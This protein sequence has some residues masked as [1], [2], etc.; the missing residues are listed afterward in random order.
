MEIQV[1]P[2]SI[3]RI[4]MMAGIAV[5]LP[6]LLASCQKSGTDGGADSKVDYYTCT[7]HPS[8]RL[9][10]PKAKCP[11]CGMDL[12]PVYKK[13]PGAHSAT[14]LSDLTER[15]SLADQVGHV[16]GAPAGASG[17]AGQDGGMFQVAPERLQ[18][19]GV[20]TEVVE[21]RSIERTLRAPGIAV[22]NESSLRDI[23][24]KVAGGFVEK[25][26]ANYEGKYVEKGQPLMTV[27]CEGWIE[28]QMDYIKAYR[29]WRRT[30]DLSP[31][32]NF[33]I[34]ENEVKRRRQRLRV[35]DLSEEQIDELEK[36]ARDTSEIDTRLARG[37][38]GTFDILSPVSGHVHKKNAIEGM[39]FEAG[40]SLLQLVDLSEI[41]IDAQFPE[42]Q[43]QYLQVGEETAITFPSQPN[44]SF[45]GKVMFI[46]PHFMEDTRRLEVRISMPN[47]HHKIRPG[48]Y[49]NVA[50]Q[51]GRGD[52]LAVSTSAV[53]PTGEHYVVFVDHGGGRLEARF[54]K[55]GETFGNYYEVVSGLTKGERVVSS[56]NFLIDAESRIQG[57]LK[58][59]GH[60]SE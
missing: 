35:W 44:Q 14:N 5:I 23:N 16:H 7:M 54:I 4:L 27:L 24:L 15:P 3:S 58:T 32:N 42:D 20:T 12:V 47:P 25:L 37:L 17:S 10:D 33:Y 28:A 6:G 13:A 11:I 40:Q 46:N 9:K 53:I 34:L 26:Y 19:I 43:A 55:V 57:A 8:V 22:I 48:M 49:A 60:R 51:I 59:W 30:A 39:R 18:S 29:K 1:I 50:V 56:A 52:V 2:K 38:K 21:P 45:K 36:L 31:E 41:W